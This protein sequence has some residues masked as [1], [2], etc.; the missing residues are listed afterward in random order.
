MAVCPKCNSSRITFN[1]E[2][3]GFRK[4]PAGSIRE[5]R[6]VGVCQNCGHTWV[7]AGPTFEKNSHSEKKP[8]SGLAWGIGTLVLEL[9]ATSLLYEIASDQ[10]LSGTGERIF[11]YVLLVIILLFIFTTWSTTNEIYTNKPIPKTLFN[12]FSVGFA[13]YSLVQIFPK[14]RW[15][16]FT[17]VILMI[18]FQYRHVLYKLYYSWKNTSNPSSTQDKNITL[19]MLSTLNIRMSN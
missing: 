18:I 11:A 2:D 3:A 7:V 19:K 6:T 10:K 5:H 4:T 14:Y 9:L 12:C 15:L 13:V 1:R 16:L 8:K 17:A